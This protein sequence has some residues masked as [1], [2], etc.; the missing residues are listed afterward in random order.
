MKDETVEKTRS[1]NDLSIASD[2]VVRL[3]VFA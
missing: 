2:A 1:G 3:I